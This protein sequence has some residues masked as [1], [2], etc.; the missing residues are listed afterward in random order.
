M[1]LLLLFPSN[2][3]CHELLGVGLCAL[4]LYGY[5]DLEQ[6]KATKMNDSSRT[7][8]LAL[9]LPSFKQQLFLQGKL[10]SLF[11]IQVPDFFSDSERVK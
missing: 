8:S 6:R 10:N 5:C 3:F 4:S 11:W 7:E 9:G 1:F 2:Y